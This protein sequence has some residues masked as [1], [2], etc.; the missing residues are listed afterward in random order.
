[1]SLFGL[2]FDFRNPELAGTPMADRYRAALEMTEW[3]DG[4]GFVV[5]GLSEHHASD[6]GYLP[7]PLTMAAAMAART[8]NIRIQIAALI[9]PFYDPLRLAEDIAVVDQ[10]SAGRLD[11]VIA[12]GYVPGEFAMFGREISERV[13]RTTEAVRTLKQAWTGEPFEFRGRMVRVT[14]TPYQDGG[15]A[16]SLGGSSPAAARRA[17][18]IADGFI[19]SNPQVWEP[20]REEMLALGKPDP[21]PGFGADTSAFFVAADAEQGWVD[22]APYAMHEMNAYGTWLQESGV[23]AAG[24]YEPVVDV[25]ALRATGQ[26]RVL[27]PDALLAEVRAKGPFGFTMLHPLCGG[28]PPAMAWESLRLFEHEVLPRL[29]AAA[30]GT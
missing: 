16:I 9:A 3:A 19:P 10:I 1:M 21:G 26:Y 14:P 17:A 28:V 27:T 24:G 23:G 8:R 12:N 11:L 5:V 7:S 15:P 13:A 22:Y 20:Y 25:D 4:L 18:R 30:P 6:D 2:R 29:E